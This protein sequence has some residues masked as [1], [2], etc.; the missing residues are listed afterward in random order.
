MMSVSQKS[1]M[2]RTLRAPFGFALAFLAVFPIAASM[3]A[4]AQDET[5]LRFPTERPKNGNFNR[6]GPG[7][8][9]DVSPPGFCWWRA[10]ERGKVSYRLRVRNDEGEEVYVSPLLDEPAHVPDK[11]LPAGSYTWTVEALTPS[12]SI[13]DTRP[14]SPFAISEKA[15]ALE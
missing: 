13:A 14:P 3:R 11:A 9:V 12:G 15:V 5:G 7:D 4:W 10:C 6:P 2:R 8:V 1:A